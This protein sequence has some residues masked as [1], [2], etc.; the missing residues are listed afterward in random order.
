M[1]DEGAAGGGGGAAGVGRGR[2]PGQVVAVDGGWSRS[3]GLLDGGVLH[4]T[5]V[6][7][8]AVHRLPLGHQVPFIAP[9]LGAAV[10]EPHLHAA[11]S[12][13]IS[14]SQIHSTLP[15]SQLS[16]Q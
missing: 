5:P 11:A 1:V 9:E 7:S 6:S 12:Q 14:Q 8:G 4:G 15:I 3:D 2:G 10:L 16:N 13:P